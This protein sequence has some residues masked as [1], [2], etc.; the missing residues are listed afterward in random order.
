MLRFFVCCAVLFYGA[1]VSGQTVTLKAKNQPLTAVLKTIQKQTSYRFVYTK[2]Q[3]DAAKPVTVNVTNQP[4]TQVLDLCFNDQKISYEIQVADRIIIIKDKPTVTISVAVAQSPAQLITGRVTNRDKEPLQGA[5]V[6]VEGKTR[7][8]ITNANGEYRIYAAPDEQLIFSFVN[9]QQERVAVKDRSV[10]DV[11]MAPNVNIMEEVTISTGY[12][13]IEQKYLTG[14]VTRLNMDSIYQPGLTTVDKMLEGRVPG[15]IM[16]QNSGQA[17]AAPKLRIRGTSTY[18]G[19]REPL[20]VVDGIVQVDPVPIAANR[21]NDLDFVNLVGNAIS[22]INPADIQSIDVLKDAAA[23]ALYGVRAANGV[24]V[25]TTKTGIPGP[26]TIT[27]NG[28][29]N[30]T[31]RPRYTDRDVAM[32]NSLERVDVSRELIQRQIPIKG[33]PEAYEKATLDYYNGI[34]DYDTYKRR[35]D[36][37]ETMNTDWLGAVT[38]DVIA[39]SHTLSISG[40]REA[41]N[42]YASAGYTDEQG[43]IKGEFNKRYTGMIKFMLNHKNLKTQFS[44][45]ANKNDR[46]YTP[47]ELAILN[48][49]YS[50]SRAI[51]LYN[52]DGSLYYFTTVKRNNGELNLRPSFNVLNE[53]EH[54]GNT[55]DGGGY[56]ATANINYQLMRGLQLE[57]ILS[58]TSSNT[59]Q[60]TWFGEKTNWVDLAKGAAFASPQENPI[61]FGGELRQQNT[62]QNAY[63]IRANAIFNRFLDQNKKHMLNVMLGGEVISTKMN[64][65]S[66]MS[67]GYYPERGHSFAK[68]DTDVYTAYA[69]WFSANGQPVILE[70]LTNMLSALVTGS[71][72]YND[73]YVLTASTKSEFSNAF[74]SR[75]NERFLPTWGISGRWNI[76]RDLLKNA[77]WVNMAA[78]R[79]SYGTQGAML[80]GQTP[81]TIIQKGVLQSN[82]QAFGS[83]IAFFP[84]PNLKWEKTDAYNAGLDFSFFNNRLNGSIGFFYKKTTNAFLD[85]RVSVINGVRSYIVNSGTIENKGVELGF[86][87]TPLNTMLGSEQKKLVWR[88]DPQLGQVFN[89]LLNQALNKDEEN[90]ITDPGAITYTDFLSGRAA[91]NGKSVNTFY[92]YRFRRLDEKGQPVFYGAEPE[93]ASALAEKYRNMS[94]EDVFRSVMTEVGRREP[95]MQGGISNYIAY[96]SLSLNLM[97]TYSLGNKIRLLN[98]VSGNYGTYQP[99]GQQNLRREFVDRWR[100]PGDELYT[101]IPGL[102][103]R[104]VTPLWWESAQVV[105]FADDYYHMYDNADIR[106]VNGNYLKLQYASL[107]YTCTQKLCQQLRLKAAQLSLSGSNLF[108][109]AHKDLK[110]QDPT[111]TGSSS[112]IN[113]GLRPVYVFAINVSF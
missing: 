24:I 64:N 32:M 41:S 101:N 22:G 27:Y 12:Q 35:V 99:S 92:A 56:S 81:Y 46:S 1:H 111:Q 18:L 4:L 45:M 7:T 42:I 16:M 31:R 10:I 52:E 34:I 75:S 47:G 13:K 62:Q 50:T 26:P 102:S 68:I 69:D 61:P 37:A 63:T 2:S 3:M 80:P 87:F 66:Q 97:L 108:T 110:G 38:Q 112:N 103:P 73:R 59:E 57:T 14:S 83:T 72:I 96:G 71:Y 104:N 48:Y 98:I 9:Y 113:L 29:V 53:M 107:N 90:V 106:V 25:I 8:M 20:W 105:A 5:S 93:N 78:L 21:I 94:V 86:N 44:I 95:I 88:I 36:R 65:T 58:Y 30:F 84:N 100:N 51:P 89:K 60:R 79:L 6:Q 67:R 85:R 54:S 109:W 23:T 82:Y 33:V 11:V 15:L 74:G 91:V 28:N 77:K 49:A 40:G 17:G 39:S 70:G 76:D 55:L 19:T 43:V